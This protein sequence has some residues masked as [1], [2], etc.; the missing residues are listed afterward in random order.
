MKD[1]SDCYTVDF[2]AI[3]APRRRGRKRVYANDAERMAAF[4][5]RRGLRT[6]TVDISP[7]VY[8]DLDSF[9]RRRVDS[10]NPD[11]TKAQVVERALKYFLRKR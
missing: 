7:A 11:E 6:L 9:M 1:S 4:R 2:C 10:D 3:P 8:D 5:A